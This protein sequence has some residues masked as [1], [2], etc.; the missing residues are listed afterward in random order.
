MN[1]HN[2]LLLS[3][4]FS[5]V[6][7]FA[8]NDAA[9][10]MKLFNDGK[11]AEVVD[12]FEQQYRQ[13]PTDFYE[14]L[15]V[16]YT[17]LK[18]YDDAE[19][20]IG[21]QLKK[22]RNPILY[23]D[24]GY[25]QGLNKKP[26]EAEE[27]YQIALNTIAQNPGLAYMY[28]EKF[29][30]YGLYKLALAAFETAERTDPNIVFHYQKALVYA[31]LG[32]LENMYKEYLE[33]ISQN[34]SY[35][36]NVQQRIANNITD[37]P[38]NETNM[39]LRRQLIKKIQET[40]NILY[41]DLLIWLYIEEG[42]YAQAFRQLKAL[43]KRNENQEAKIISLGQR[44]LAKTQ[45]PIALESFTYVEGK[46]EMGA[47]FEEAIYLKLQ[48][49]RLQLRATPQ[50]KKEDFLTLL[51]QHYAALKP[52]QGDEKYVFTERDIAGILYFDLKMSDSATH[53]LERTIAQ[54]GNV[55]KKPV[56]ECKMML[57]DIL[58]AQGESIEAIFKYMEVERA[59]NGTPLGDE[60]KFMKAK[61]AYFTLDFP[62][63]LSQFE[64]LK[65]STTKLI[66]NDALQMALLISDN[67]TEDTLFQ[68]LSYYAKADLFQFRNMPDS[69]ILTLNLLLAVF[70]EHAIKAEA[71][72]LEANLY[73]KK[74]QY[75]DAV[76][77]L[78]SMIANSTDVWT[79]DALMLLGDIYANRLGD[80]ENA[81]LA[82][83]KILFEHP[84]STFVPEARRQYRALR[85]DNL[86]N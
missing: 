52:L 33:M 51:N 11:Y 71:L 13:N 76:S 75:Q 38:A 31:E 78:N 27:S 48:T 29:S 85:G 60:A 28:S 84:G 39:V 37:D 2:L 9:E 4:L 1:K 86:T 82:Y 66:S 5:A 3:L 54:F 32:D 67:S 36:Q 8:Q 80:K 43:D 65:S 15:R 42:E 30:S 35:Y 70:P 41:T 45:Y 26:T 59:F 21:K 63:A 6:L 25:I 73:Y 77:T 24:L 57:G 74:G 12:Y 16:C 79:D 62:W 40:Q 14:P 64:V 7:A 47:Y 56:A 61:V 10:K 49:L 83:E 69:A 20:L 23:I 55:Y 22:T 46:G 81:M 19:K 50:Q 18:R 58:L 44:A 17:A 34:A 72:L 68:G 53:V